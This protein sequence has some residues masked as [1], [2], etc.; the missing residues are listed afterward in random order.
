MPKL[1]EYQTEA[2]SKTHCLDRLVYLISP[3]LGKTYL[4]ADFL[5]NRKVTKGVVTAPLSVCPTW[6]A[7]L[8]EFGLKTIRGYKGSVSDALTRLEGAKEGILVINDDRLHSMRHGIVKWGPQAF[9]GDESHRFRG[10]S[11]S[12]GKALRLVSRH[13]PLLRLLTGTPSPN[14]LG[15]LW[16]QYTAVNPK[17]WGT[18][19]EK[20]AQKFLIRDQMF[21]S[22]VL[23]VMHEDVLRDMLLTDS[24]ML[25]REDVYGPDT[26]QEVYRQVELPPAAAKV[27]KSLVN[28]WFAELSDTEAVNAD[29]I[30]KRM[31]RLQQLTSG[32][33]IDEEGATHALHDAKIEA[34]MS[35]LEDIVTSGETAI[36]FHRFTPEGDTLFAKANDVFRDRAKIVKINGSVRTAD[37]E[38]AM[39]AVNESSSPVICIVQTQAGG[40][41]ISLKG[42]THALFMSQSFNFDDEQ[43]A[44]DRI[45][46]PGGRKCVTYYRCPNTVDSYIAQVLANKG[47]VH[48]AVRHA[49]ISELAYGQTTLNKRGM[50]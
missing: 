29:H 50:V 44:R 13:V 36:V 37:R 9:V 7:V 23:G 46:E 6:E 45:Y 17:A 27:Y 8:A 48:N 31:T 47:N 28:E 2:A 49:D 32:Y 39:R 5:V 20:F 38:L 16:G 35:D 10:V 3:R 34:V 33:T 40:T 26:W 21:P 14:H 4:A 11:S 30:L 1:R 22:R 19:Y 25:R 42:A 41:G 18:S 12:R 15:N 24:Y 43:Q